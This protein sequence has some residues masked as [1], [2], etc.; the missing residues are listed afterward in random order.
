VRLPL[1]VALSVAALA[2]SG[3]GSSSPASTASSTESTATQEATASPLTG[4]SAPQASAQGADHS[5][6][7]YGAKASGEQ[8]SAPVAA[9]RSFFRAMSTGEHAGI[10]AGLAAANVKELSRFSKQGGCPAA[11]KLL[12]LKDAEPAAKAAARAPVQS[13]RIKGDTAFVLFTPKGGKPSFFV[14]KRE[15]GAWKSISPAPGTPLQP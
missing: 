12:N 14:M 6:Q 8:A 5:V 7:E 9:M 2:A 10:C 4:E 1:V 15:G 11:L 13:V 3:C